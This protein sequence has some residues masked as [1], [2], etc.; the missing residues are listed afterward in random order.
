MLFGHAVLFRLSLIA[1]L[2]GLTACSRYRPAEAPAAP[3]ASAPV[4]VEANTAP[5][6]AAP[7]S[8]ERRPSPESPRRTN[9]LDKK[10]LVSEVIARNPNVAARRQA[11]RAARAR[12][13]QADSLDDPVLS[14]EFAPLS[15]FSSNV[16]YGQTVK[17]SQRFP[18]PGKL[19]SRGDAEDKAADARAEEVKVTELDLALDASNL[20]DDYWLMDRSL[21]VNAEHRRLLAE[22]K[23]NAE[24]QYSVGRASLSD[25]LQA[26]VE[27]TELLQQDVGLKSRRDVIVAQLNALLHRAPELPLAAPPPQLHVDLS[28]PPKSSELQQAALDQSPELAALAARSKSAQAK[29]RYAEKQYYPDITLMATYTS[30]FMAVEHQFMVG[31]QAP[32]PIHLGRR[33]GAVDEAKAQ[34]AEVRS[35][36][37]GAIDDIRADVESSRRRVIEMIEVVKL[38]DARLIPTAKDQVAATRADFAAGKTDFSTVILAEKKLRNIEL[39]RHVAVAELSKR[40]AR[41]SRSVGRMPEGTR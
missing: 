19:S 3:A 36:T 23:G 38:Y 16:P 34:I 17:L 15:I 8:A 25:P 26:E 40:R 12:R 1:A 13:P 32:I 27:L 33:D 2:A 5:A 18:W 10:R 39:A 22:L 9:T 37:L 14:Y 6:S 31:V 4:R 20:Y 21:D 7:I 28:A 41:L 29:A 24:A 30:M 35:D 11:W